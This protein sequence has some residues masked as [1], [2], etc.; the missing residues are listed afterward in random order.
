MTDYINPYR[1]F[2]GLFVP[3]WLARQPAVSL[4]AKLTYG[5]LCQYANAET[6][7]AWPGQDTLAASIG[8][9]ERSV[10]DYL[11]ELERL[12]LI[13]TEQLGFSKT[14]RYRF[15]DH[16]WMHRASGQERQD[17]AGQE[18]QDAAGQGRQDSAGAKEEIQLRD[19]ITPAPTT[20]DRSVTFSLADARGLVE[21]WWQRQSPAPRSLG[22]ATLA[23]RVHALVAAGWPDGLVE[24][25][26][27]QCENFTEAAIEG[28]LRGL[29][30][31]G[32]M[33]SPPAGRG[34]AV[35]G[36]S[37]KNRGGSDSAQTNEAGQT[38]LPGSGWVD[39]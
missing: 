13:E 37:S 26:L 23:K 22:K 38:F 21:R 3:N 14:N 12:R 17:S 4:G 5:S 6:G 20:T 36:L 15:L 27:D 9:S 19:P 11:N 18:Q 32:T 7:I 33:G 2:R 25:A 16:P 35:A 34:G 30:A 29:R 1:L 31:T 28:R 10:R 8:K 24:D 39:K